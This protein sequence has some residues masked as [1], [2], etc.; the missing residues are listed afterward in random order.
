M[1]VAWPNSNSKDYKY[2]VWVRM[3][4]FGNK[5]RITRLFEQSVEDIRKQEAEILDIEPMFTFSPV[6]FVNLAIDLAIGALSFDISILISGSIESNEAITMIGFMIVIH[7]VLLMVIIFSI[8]FIR[9][10]APDKE[11]TRNSVATM[12]ITMGLMAMITA[13]IAL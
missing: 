4:Q 11:Q 13:V 9:Q 7:L 6:G 3:L 2:V 10:I 5:F 12:A 8:M 1:L